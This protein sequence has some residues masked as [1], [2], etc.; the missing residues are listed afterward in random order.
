[1]TNDPHPS[2]PGPANPL[3]SRDHFRWD[4]RH[5]QPHTDMG[6]WEKF[7]A[8]RSD[9]AQFTRLL[10][11]NFARLP[12]VVRRYRALRRA[13]A[14]AV[15]VAD[16][17]FGIAVSPTR[18][19]WPR[20]LE[21]ISALG[22]RALLFRVP[23]WAPNPVFALHDELARLR[24]E[25]VRFTFALA[26]NR[27]M[28]NDPA[29][30]GAFVRDAA[31]CFS[32]VGPA[33]QLGHAINRKKWGIWHPDEYLRLMEAAAPAREAYPSC[34]WL[35]PPVIDFE[36]YFTTHYLV[37]PRPFDFDGIASLLYV[38]R[39]GSPDNLQ[40]AHFDLSRKIALLRAVVQASGHPDVPI[41]LTEFNWPLLGSG[42]HSPAGE[43]VQTN[44]EG[45]ARY[46]VLYYLTAAATGHVASAFWWQLV[47]RGY[48]LLD[49]DDAWSERRSYR[50]FGHLLA[51][52]RGRA[53]RRLPESLR[54]LRGFLL[55]GESGT[56]A[57]LY[58]ASGEARLDAGLR[59][60]SAADLV[61]APIPTARITVGPDP[62]YLTL[63][64]ADPA[65]ILD[66]LNPRRR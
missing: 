55:A 7:F 8:S 23:S 38:D 47:A 49:E 21:R 5:H 32:D 36:Y 19:S 52:T 25:G 22:A 41:H 64:A 3:R 20:Y 57:V 13:D 12:A 61:G 6:K 51:R 65:E 18:E 45:Q 29:G 14:P 24:A 60:E 58:A 10:G 31:A 9:A 63:G 66:V 39:R 4:D 28:V 16:D 1:M 56:D 17:A 53:V 40:Y 43:H 35:G 42:K 44:E 37:E 11:H 50:A 30:W 33:L 26:Q 59:I 34:R 2:D 15:T 62:I 54:P 27:E 46:L 48:G